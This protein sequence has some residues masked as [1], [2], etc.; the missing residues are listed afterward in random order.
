[1]ADRV[2]Q[3]DRDELAQA[4]RIPDRRRR[5]RVHLDPHAGI[6]RGLRQRCGGLGG[7]VVELERN[8]L[9]R[10]GA[11]VG[12]SQQEQV[13]DEPG[14]LLDLGVDVGEGV[15]DL[16]HRA[17]GVPPQQLHRAPD[18]RQWGPQLV[19]RVG[20]ELA[21]APQRGALG[22][23]RV[24]D[25]HERAARVDR[26]E[27]RRHEDDHEPADHEHEHEALERPNLGGPVLDDLDEEPALRGVRRDG[28]LPDRHGHRGPSA[29]ALDRD[30][31]EAKVAARLVRDRRCVAVRQALRDVELAG[32]DGRAVRG[33]QDR[34]RAARRRR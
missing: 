23:E 6:R 24:A 18:D 17:G 27:P 13:V 3:Q 16:A 8:P 20:R 33:D 1:M 2:V 7:H 29:G 21:L 11:G 14:E 12:A 32:P 5:R 30:G 31:G 15:P 4:G 34:E 26:P 28:Q 9:E 19:A 25:R 22:R 10:D